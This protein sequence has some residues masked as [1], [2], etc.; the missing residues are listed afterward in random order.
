MVDNTLESISLPSPGNPRRVKRICNSTI[1][2][3]NLPS[4]P[5]LHGKSTLAAT[6]LCEQVSNTI[7]V[8]IIEWLVLTQAL[9]Q[10]G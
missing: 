3:N 8:M 7:I 10:F 6:K 1:T 9:G 4:L 5:K 2:T